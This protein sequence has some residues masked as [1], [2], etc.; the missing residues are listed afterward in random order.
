MPSNLN[1]DVS[2]GF[3]GPQKKPTLRASNCHCAV[4]RVLLLFSAFS[5]KA[6]SSP[7][8]GVA[9]AELLWAEAAM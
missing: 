8:C 1:T 6:S 5:T 7:A 2:A 3:L 4:L 9:V